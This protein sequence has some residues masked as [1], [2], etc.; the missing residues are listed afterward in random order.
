MVVP[1]IARG[2]L[3]GAK[4]LSKTPAGKK[5]L[6]QAISKGKT[7]VKKA[8]PKKTKPKIDWSKAPRDVK[9]KTKTDW[10]KVA[11]KFENRP[12]KKALRTALIKSK[13]KPRGRGAGARAYATTGAA[14]G[15]AGLAASVGKGKSRNPRTRKRKTA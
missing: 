5:L 14:V 8:K 10:N 13:A 9:A 1:V 12:S 2:L 4:A 6:K 11:K 3:A 15:G 7:L